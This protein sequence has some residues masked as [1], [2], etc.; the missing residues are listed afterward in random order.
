MGILQID[1]EDEKENFSCQVE[2]LQTP[3]ENPFAAFK[4]I[5]YIEKISVRGSIFYKS[6]LKTL[7]PGSWLND[8]IINSYMELLSDHYTSTYFFSSFTYSFLRN[9][10]VEKV[11]GW[12]EDIDIE[13]YD[14]YVFPIHS[15]SHWSLV[16]IKDNEFYGMDSMSIM[17]MS[18][19][20]RIRSLMVHIFA[21]KKKKFTGIFGK[22]LKRRIPQQE[23]GDDCGVFCCAYA[24]YF[25]RSTGYDEF[26]S[27]DIPKLRGMILH[28]ILSG[29]MLY[30]QPNS[31]SL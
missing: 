3:F 31:Q 6:D 12:Y 26:S 14:S 18:V 25:L 28:E 4:Y 30:C 8:K 10:P 27:K 29:R 21:L 15:Q 2:I 23:N 5:K 7:I 20:V 1:S 19:V 11:A 17:E 16:V 13:K 24:R 9:N 22:L